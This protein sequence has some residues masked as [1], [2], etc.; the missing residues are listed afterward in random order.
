M[1]T[2]I[3]NN[4]IGNETGIL[5]TAP[6]AENNFT[7]NSEFNKQVS[8]KE[9]TYTQNDLTTY[10]MA[11][12]TTNGLQLWSIS[13]SGYKNNGEDKA[14]EIN[15]SSSSS[16]TSSS[17]GLIDNL[18]IIN[19]KGKSADNKRKK[20][21]YNMINFTGYECSRFVLRPCFGG[22]QKSFLLIGS[23]NGEINIWNRLNGLS[24]G[25]IK[26]HK[27]VI[28]AITWCPGSNMFISCSIMDNGEN[29]I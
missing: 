24:I 14:E 22:Y 21:I 16:S 8:I 20:G 11:V 17:S 1:K 13:M 15:Y 25:K 4:K 23:N 9:N 19:L 7:N 18:N 26:A 5:L 27:S 6:A 12:S 3:V 28:N 10:N 29:K 2:D